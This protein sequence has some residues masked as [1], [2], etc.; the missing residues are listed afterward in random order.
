MIGRTLD[1]YVVIQFLRL[2]FLFALAA[3]LLFIIIDVT[4]QLDSH[5]DR[6]LPWDD[7][8]LSYVYLFPQFVLWAFPV[9]ALIA[10]IFTVNGMTRHFE[11]TAAKAGG[12]SFF[13]LYASLPIAG[14]FLTILALGLSELVPITIRRQA[15]VLGER[16]RSVGSR[17]D[18]V[19][20]STDGRTFAIPRLD[21]ANG[22]LYNPTMEHS[23]APG[24]WRGI[25]AVA[26]E[27]SYSTELGGWIME[28]GYLR[29]LGDDG[30]EST[31]RFAELIPRGFDEPP[32]E[33]LA[34]QKEPDEMRYAEL[35][36]FIE[37][38]ERA[39][40][41]TLRLQ[42]DLAEKL[43]IPVATLIII[44]FAGPLAASAPRGGA[45]YGVGI[46][47]GIT[48]LY[49]L[50]FRLTGALGVGG[51]VPPVIAAWSPNILF[52]ATGLLLM[53]RVRT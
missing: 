18:F 10:T 42:V 32:D 25:H 5:L 53:T 11:V 28:N 26:E 38:V 39:G 31:F 24:E 4:D 48:I 3:P 2:F 33:L 27:G 19:Y 46:S 49:L 44:L 6:G 50:L 51:T 34:E 22:R 15:E 36:S 41:N 14:I 8:A 21:A 43:A 45:A 9:A 37:V 20:R 12:I 47:L 23:E 13:R 17:S 35:A 30:E 52:F 40:G 7:I 16:T 29:L 1:R